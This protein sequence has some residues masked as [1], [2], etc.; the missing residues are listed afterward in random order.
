MLGA[1]K[2]KGLE[3]NIPPS[4]K[5]ELWLENTIEIW[6]EAACGDLDIVEFVIT[7]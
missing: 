7:K 2:V 1:L 4:S 3:K 6:T 5:T